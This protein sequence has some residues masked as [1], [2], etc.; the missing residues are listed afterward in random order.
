LTVD[1]DEAEALAL[2]L[3]EAALEEA[4]EEAELVALVLAAEDEDEAEA[5]E[6]VAEALAAEEELEVVDPV[7]QLP[8]IPKVTHPSCR[9]ATTS[10]PLLTGAAVAPVAKRARTGRREYIVDLRVGG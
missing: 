10:L 7:L 5:L 2:E 6:E 8:R 4:L 1:E 3:E 9:L